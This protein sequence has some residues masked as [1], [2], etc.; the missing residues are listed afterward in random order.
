MY[1]QMSKKITEFTESGI[2]LTY[3]ANGTARTQTVTCPSC[4]G[5]VVVWMVP[6]DPDEPPMDMWNAI[7]PRCH[8]VVVMMLYH[9]P[10]K[11]DFCA[12]LGVDDPPPPPD[13]CLEGEEVDTE[14]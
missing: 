5:P 11:D 3:G 8:K 9:E 13:Y 14:E 12:P 1:E 7:C 4:G 6:D 2:P 10:T